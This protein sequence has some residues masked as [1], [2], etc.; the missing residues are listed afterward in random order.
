MLQELKHKIIDNYKNSIGS[1][2]VVTTEKDAMRLVNTPY[3]Y[4]FMDVPIYAIP[5][6]VYFSE[7]DNDKF[8][9]TILNYVEGRR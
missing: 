7:K 1:T 9:S 2:I 3:L 5:I 6:E 4:Y 8:N